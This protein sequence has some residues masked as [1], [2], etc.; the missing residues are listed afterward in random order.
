MQRPSANEEQS[1]PRDTAFFRRNRGNAGFYGTLRLV[2]HPQSKWAP[3]VAHGNGFGG[4]AL[5]CVVFSETLPPRNWESGC[6]FCN[7][8]SR[9]VPW[10]VEKGSGGW[11]TAPPPA[12]PL[13]LPGK[14]GNRFPAPPARILARRAIGRGRRFG[15][16]GPPFRDFT[17]PRRRGR[18]AGGNAR[19]GSVSG[20]E[21]G[22][23]YVPMRL[24]PVSLASCCLSARRGPGGGGA[25]LAEPG[26]QR[27]NWRAFTISLVPRLSFVPGKAVPEGPLGWTGFRCTLR[28]L[29]DVLGA[30]NGLGAKPGKLRGPFRALPP[31]G[32]ARFFLWYGIEGRARV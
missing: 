9:A 16:R 25:L 13:P 7:P 4:R 18:W 1:L 6:H 10:T 14:G 26:R 24:P 8:K 21:A 31:R 19:T 30:Q 12:C 3:F 11:G 22:G 32:W 23:R 15:V 27:A 2:L 5:G 29:T 17:L 28:R 20:R